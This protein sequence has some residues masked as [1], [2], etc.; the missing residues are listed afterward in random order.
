M[1]S[2]ES[3]AG[4]YHCPDCRLGF[5]G[6]HY[7]EVGEDRVGYVCSDCG[8]VVNRTAGSIDIEGIAPSRCGSCTFARMA[9]P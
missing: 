4:P 1:G 5:E 6:Y 8:E 3:N 2:E 7:C 9:E